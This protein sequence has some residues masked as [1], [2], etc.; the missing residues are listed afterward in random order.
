MLT[1]HAVL[2]SMVCSE[3][4]HSEIRVSDRKSSPTALGSDMQLISVRRQF[5]NR[6]ARFEREILVGYGNGYASF[7]MQAGCA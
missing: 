4:A 6:R 2:V 1:I 3:G 7:D 5:W